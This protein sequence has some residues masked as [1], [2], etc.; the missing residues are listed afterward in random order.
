MAVLPLHVRESHFILT[1]V[2]M[3]ALTTM[4]LWLSVRAARLATVRGYAWAAAAA[5]LAAAAKYNGGI[6]LV[7]VVAAY[8]LNERSS[9]DRLRK[10]GVIAGA[11]VLGFLIGAPYTI[12]DLPAFLDGFAAQF[13][14]FTGPSRTADPAWLLYLKHLSPPGGR[15]PVPL[16]IA[17]MA[18]LAWRA[19]TRVRWMPVILFTLAYFYILST[20]SVVFGRY[21]LP[22]VPPLCLFTSVAVFEA[23][24]AASR[25]R[26]LARPAARRVLTAAVVILLVYGYA[27]MT[28]RWLDLQ[29]RSDT[30]SLA[31]EWLRNNTP[32]A[33]RVAV[34]NNGP[35]YLQ[36]AGFRVTGTE[37]LLDKDVEWYRQR[38]D[39]LVIS[40][41][42][43][44]RYGA[45]V[46]A[47]PTVFQISPTLQRWGPPILIV[48]LAAP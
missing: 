7:A 4:T 43:L 35:T 29:K 14:R 17:G 16:A 18:I 47:G 32:R 22:L 33:A 6:A 34:E 21:A 44:A 46:S 1:D 10:L 31:A 28:V 41:A 42:D 30:R 37:L 23:I 26:T 20:H 3:T 9:A 12:L 19:S 40:T 36:T 38:V 25:L 48:R 39:Y 2:P 5:G 8:L 11:A 15:W 45:Y 24:G 27:V 13:S